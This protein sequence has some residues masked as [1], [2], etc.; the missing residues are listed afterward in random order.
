M[1]SNNLI[2]LSTCWY[3]LKSKFDIKTYLPNFGGRATS[4][5][6]RSVGRL[7]DSLVLKFLSGPTPAYNYH[8]LSDPSR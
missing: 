3:I 2:T 5:A 1:A 8:F 4:E 7:G 6:G